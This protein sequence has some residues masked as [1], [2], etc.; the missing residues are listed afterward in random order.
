MTDEK[1]IGL[2]ISTLFLPSNYQ[3]IILTA[4]MTA[5]VFIIRKV[6]SY[7]NGNTSKLYHLVSENKN[8]IVFG[9]LV[10]GFI[11]LILPYADVYTKAESYSFGDKFNQSIQ[12]ITVG[13]IFAFVGLFSA[14]VGYK[15]LKLPSATKKIE[16]TNNQNIK[17]DKCKFGSVKFL[18]K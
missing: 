9:L 2:G 18:K 17:T 11:Q 16:A 15:R 7:C 4:L 5:L 14:S 1:H 12:F 13:L 6:L 10:S 8:M 3:S